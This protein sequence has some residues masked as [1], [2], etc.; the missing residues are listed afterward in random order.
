MEGV[1]SVAEDKI[2]IIGVRHIDTD[3]VARREI[4]DDNIATADTVSSRKPVIV[5]QRP[6][7]VGLGPVMGIVFCVRGMPMGVF[8]M[9]GP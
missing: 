7:E 8:G 2:I 6:V 5:P 1:Y 9:R 4:E 3:S